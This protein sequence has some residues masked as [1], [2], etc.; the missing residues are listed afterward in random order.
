M[1]SFVKTDVWE[2]VL[3]SRMMKVSVRMSSVKRIEKKGA[4]V[5]VVVV[6]EEDD[7]RD[8]KI[9]VCLNYSS[10]RHQFSHV[11]CLCFCWNGQSGEENGDEVEHKDD[12]GCVRDSES[13]GERV[14][15][16]RRGGQFAVVNVNIGQDV[17]VSSSSRRRRSDRVCASSMCQCVQLVEDGQYWPLRYDGEGPDRCRIRNCEVVRSMR[18]RRI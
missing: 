7:S 1:K 5:E 6:E 15:E 3:F 12:N 17:G 18:N 14:G 4:I 9:V 13:V 10:Y 2:A 8:D 11:L 16:R